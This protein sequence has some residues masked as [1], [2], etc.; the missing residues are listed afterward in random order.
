MSPDRGGANQNRD[1]DDQADGP[2][3]ALQSCP[4]RLPHFRRQLFQ[5]RNHLL[6]TSGIRVVADSAVVVWPY[7]Q[8][9]P[10][11]DDLSP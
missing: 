7:K 3:P 4:D 2:G 5:R 9:S 10:R 11:D 1:Q 6:S 8:K